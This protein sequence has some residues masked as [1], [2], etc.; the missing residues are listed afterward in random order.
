MVLTLYLLLLL[1]LEVA[2]EVGVMLGAQT[3][4]AVWLAVL[5]AERGIIIRVLVLLYGL[6]VL[7]QAV[8]DMQVV[9]VLTRH[10]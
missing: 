2:A 3:V 4:L 6:V 9:E 5:A 10:I 1:L 8:K 7:A